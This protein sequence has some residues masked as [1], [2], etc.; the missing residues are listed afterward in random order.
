ME[1]NYGSFECIVEIPAGYDVTKAQAA[2][3]NGFLRIDVPPAEAGSTPTIIPV[4]SE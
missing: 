3:H 2:Y 1:I 4:T